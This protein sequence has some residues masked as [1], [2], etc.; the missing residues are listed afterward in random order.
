MKKSRPSSSYIPIFSND[1]CVIFLLVAL[2]DF[3]NP[4]S[5]YVR[6]FFRLWSIVFSEKQFLYSALL[7]GC[8][9]MTCSFIGH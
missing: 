5:V 4:F 6:L 2:S 9:Q 3:A 1:T 7:L 8:S